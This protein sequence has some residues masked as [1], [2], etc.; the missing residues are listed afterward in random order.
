MVSLALAALAT[1][2]LA[3]F[4]D[5]YNFLKAVRDA[6]GA[7]VTQIISKPGSVIIDTRDQATGDSA[8]HIVTRRRDAA[9]INFLLGHGAKPDIRDK[10]GDTPLMIAVQLRFIEG[11]TALLVRKASVD[12][13][14]SSGETPLIR[15][16]QN[17]D[18]T[19]VR[20]LLG[21]GA[22]PAKADTIAGMSARDYA[23]RDTRTPALLKAID[24]AKPVKPKA[25]PSL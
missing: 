17:R 12:M 19:L 8:L 15:A 3:Q 10:R 2:A 11:A 20:A 21:A 23:T 7:K 14:N 18:L 9:W 25:G 6:D 5:S 24:E 16:V 4:S 1:P 22:N 13:A